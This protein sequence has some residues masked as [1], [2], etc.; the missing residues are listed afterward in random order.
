[1]IS[2]L[3]EFSRYTTTALQSPQWLH[4]AGPMTIIMGKVPVRQDH[5]SVPIRPN[6]DR[7]THRSAPGPG[8][9]CR[10]LD[11]QVP[12]REVFALKV[13]AAPL[14]LQHSSEKEQDGTLFFL[15]VLL[16][17]PPLERKNRAF[18]IGGNCPHPVEGS[19]HLPH[20]CPNVD[21][22]GP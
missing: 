8:C 7:W 18:I 11:P 9:H 6:H 21:E 12:F 16:W 15:K 22:T 19:C 3:R 1:M 20:A 2:S 5:S 10:G 13:C 17:S 14:F 4:F